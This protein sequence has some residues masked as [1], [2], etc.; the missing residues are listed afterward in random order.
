MVTTPQNH[1]NLHYSNNYQVAT[2]LPDHK[3]PEEIGRKKIKYW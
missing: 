2:I 1:I 3:A